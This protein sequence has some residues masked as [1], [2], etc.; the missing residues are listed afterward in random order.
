[1]GGPILYGPNPLELLYG[2]ETRPNS[3]VGEAMHTKSKVRD[4]EKY[5][6]DYAVLTFCRLDCVEKTH[7][8]LSGL[9]VEGTTA[10]LHHVQHSSESWKV[11]KVNSLEFAST[12][13]V[14]DTPIGWPTLEQ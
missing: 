9:L 12:Q 13:R 7:V 2:R 10:V 14:I 4:R 6:V 5:R 8:S 3:I 11:T 1:M